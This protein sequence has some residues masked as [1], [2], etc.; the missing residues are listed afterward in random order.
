GGEGR[1]ERASLQRAVDRAGRASF[2][3][4]F[5]DL[6]NGIPEVRLLS[7]RPLVA[8]LGHRAARS[9]RVNSD[10]LAHSICDR[11]GRLVSVD[12]HPPPLRERPPPP[13]CQP[14]PTPAARNAA[15]ARSTA[16]AAG[17]STFSSV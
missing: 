16:S 11:C 10:R 12:F 5:S 3:L 7:A 17:G 13:L 2:R 15:H 1:R 8:E 6:G 4:H 9:D 14:A